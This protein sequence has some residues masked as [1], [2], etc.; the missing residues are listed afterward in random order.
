MTEHLDGALIVAQGLL[1]MG[2]PPPSAMVAYGYAHGHV[3][4]LISRT[5]EDLD[6]EEQ[7][8]WLAQHEHCACAEQLRRWLLVSTHL[9]KRQ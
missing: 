9:E 3:A 5:W 2:E 7:A 8:A 1:M 6:P 4:W